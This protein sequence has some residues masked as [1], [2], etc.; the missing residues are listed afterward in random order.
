MPGTGGGVYLAGV[1]NFF[2]KICWGMKFFFIESVGVPN[3]V[4]LI[5]VIKKKQK[6][7]ITSF[8]NPTGTK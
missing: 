7:T 1:T 8:I 6:K 4:L 5:S 3:Y 2:N